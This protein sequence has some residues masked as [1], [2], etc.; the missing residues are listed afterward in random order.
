MKII[1]LD[2][3]GVIIHSQ[4]KYGCLSSGRSVRDADEFCV[5]LLNILVEER[6]AYVVISST[7][8]KHHKIEWMRAMLVRAGFRFPERVISVT[9]DHTGIEWTSHERG[10]EIQHWLR[11]QPEVTHYVVLDDDGDVGPI[12]KENWVLI[13]AGWHTGGMKVEHLSAALRVLK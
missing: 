3:D 2:F 5:S 6:D 13:K 11:L 8:R 9:P 1:F 4:E 10:E 7:W 12:P